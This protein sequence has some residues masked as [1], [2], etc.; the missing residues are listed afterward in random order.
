[1]VQIRTIG[2]PQC[3]SAIQKE[4]FQ[5]ELRRLDDAENLKDIDIKES[6]DFES[7]LTSVFVSK[8]D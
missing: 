2:T 3:L 8:F 4:V 7:E 1:M 5:A 6:E